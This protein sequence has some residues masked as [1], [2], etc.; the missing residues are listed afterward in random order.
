MKIYAYR[1]SDYAGV[2]VGDLHF[3]YGY[4][5]RLCPKHGKNPDC[6]DEHDCEKV[7]DC[8]VVTKKGKEIMRI[9]D[10]K[11]HKGGAEDVNH[12]LVLG[13]AYYLANL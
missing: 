12:G 7:E 2:D 6:E 11:L 9:P 5:Q 13:M 4:E 8:F 10:S 3:Y 1:A